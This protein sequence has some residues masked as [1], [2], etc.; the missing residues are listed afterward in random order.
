MGEYGVGD[1]VFFQQNRGAQ[2]IRRSTW[3]RAA[4]V[5]RVEGVFEKKYVGSCAREY[6]SA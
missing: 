6:H 4:R 1:L 2:D 5:I 3:S